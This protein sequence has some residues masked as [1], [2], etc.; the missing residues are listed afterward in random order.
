MQREWYP[1]PACFSL[2]ASTVALPFTAHIHGYLLSLY[3]CVLL[4]YWLAVPN[5]HD[6][7]NWD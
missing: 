5:T 4:Q 7:L 6:V 2:T 3:C 1:R